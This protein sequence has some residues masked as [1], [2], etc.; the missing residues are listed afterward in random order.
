MMKS[1][2]PRSHSMIEALWHMVKRSAW[3]KLFGQGQSYTNGLEQEMQTQ[4]GNQ[5][6]RRCGVGA[7]TNISHQVHHYR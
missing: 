1:R 7:D 2:V 5:A 6:E 3:H 4:C